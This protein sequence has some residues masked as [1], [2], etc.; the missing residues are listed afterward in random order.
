MKLRMPS[1]A[2]VDPEIGNEIQEI[3]G[4][5]R[6][7]P[8]AEAVGASSE[9]LARYVEAQ[10][11][12]L[13]SATAGPPPGDLEAIVRKFG[14][15]ALFVRGGRVDVP[16]SDTWKTRIAPYLPYVEPLL[17]TVGRVE[18]MGHPDYDWIG[19]A[20]VVGH[21]TVFTNRHVAQIF[22]QAD[23]PAFR[24]RR[25]AGQALSS[26]VDFKREY[27]NTAM[28]E[29]AVSKILFI[30]SDRD[31]AADAA[32]LELESHAGLPD[33]LELSDKE[34]EGWVCAV[35]YPGWDGQRNDAAVMTRIFGETYGVKRFAPGKVMD[36]SAEGI[37]F[38]HDCSTLGGNSGSVLIDLEEG[39]AVGLHF[40]GSYE[41]S[42]FAVKATELKRLLGSTTVSLA[43][44]AGLEGLEARR[45]KPK[46]KE[47][48]IREESWFEDE[49]D[50][51]RAAFL[52]SQRQVEPPGLGKWKDKVAKVG[53]GHTLKYRHFSVVVAESRRMALYTAVNIDGKKLAPTKRGNDVWYLDP[54]IDAAAQIGNAAAYT[55]NP[56]DRG[57][58]VRRLDPVWGDE[59]GQAEEDTFHYTNST[60]QH[61]ALNQR[62]WLSLEDYVMRRTDEDEMKASVFSGPVLKQ[63][64]PR[65][66]DIRL[67]R[68]YWKVA[69]AVDKQTKRLSAAGY[70]L[71]QA[72]DIE[73]LL[74]VPFGA[75]RTYQVRISEISEKTGL[76]MAH[77]EAMDAFGIEESPGAPRRRLIE[78]PDDVRLS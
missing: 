56:L 48:P 1:V 25:F 16:A 29:L 19:T 43:V 22:A 58:L 17:G 21:R 49:R 20:W 61:E 7:F 63:N 27:E 38:T 64:D 24:F 39:R 52:G 69:V 8:G 45:R 71:S 78:G 76:D 62:T 32:I 72:D 41:R 9:R 36:W 14:R 6:A 55:N 44:P 5:R 75:F 42:N 40:A 26:K 73:P 30:S 15:P 10:N 47:D 18:V 33:P 66:R 51:Y 68:E 59:A 31:D 35:G 54:R 3:I 34:P 46:T 4:R 53:D 12:G 11:S 37:T 57:H 74:E 50:G 70:I 67:P 23:G 65:Y 13:E 28:H 77:L 60:P 2:A